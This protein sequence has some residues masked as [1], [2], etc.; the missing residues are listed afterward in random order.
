MVALVGSSLV[1]P[2]GCSLLAGLPSDYG[3]AE[4]D[5]GAAAPEDAIEANPPDGGID[6]PP[7]PPVDAGRD[8][9]CGDTQSSGTNCGSCGHDCLGSACIQGVCQPVTLATGESAASEVI[10]LGNQLY[11]TTGS[12]IRTCTLPACSSPVTLCAS[13]NGFGLAGDTSNLYWS[14]SGD[15]TVQMAPT[16]GCDG[17]PGT[18]LE[19]EGAVG[20]GVNGIASDDAGVFWARDCNPGGIGTAALNGSGVTD[21]VFNEAN[22]NGIALDPNDL[23]WTNA[24]DSTNAVVRAGRDGADAGTIGSGSGAYRLALDPGAARVYWT[25]STGGTIGVAAL[26]GTDAGG[27]FA[28]SQANPAHIVVYGGAVYWTNYAQGA[29]FA[30]SVRACPVIGCTEPATLATGLN[31]PSGLAVDDQRVYWVDNGDGTVMAVAR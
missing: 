18:V 14:Q 9:G 30:G 23:Y 20:C 19:S 13:S 2:L 8:A 1:L 28:T 26:D 29:G 17:G 10:V 5:A 11:W 6:S 4:A 3:L 27:I 31:G 24:G 7:P 22:P 16:S 25:N 21:I 15:N 12:A